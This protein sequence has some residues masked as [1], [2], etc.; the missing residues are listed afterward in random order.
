MGMRPP[1]YVPADHLVEVTGRTIQSRFLMR[2]DPVTRDLILGVLGRAQARYRVGIV[3]FVFLSNHYHMLLLP[4]SP[5]QLAEFM[6][7]V[8]SNIARELGRLHGWNARFWGRRYTS[9]PV[10]QEEAAQ[11]SR[12]RYLLA[13]GVKE[14]LVTRVREWPGPNSALAHLDG[15]AIEG[16]WFDRTA[17]SRAR[18]SGVVASL[19]EFASTERVALTP[20][21]C[22]STWSPLQRREAVHQLVADIESAGA[23]RGTHPLGRKAILRQHPHDMPTN[24]KRTPAPVFHAMTKP[25][26][27]ALSD[28]YRSFVL[29]F[30]EASERLRSGVRLV[31]FPPGSFP[32]ALPYVPIRAG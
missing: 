3:A 23:L 10:S 13:H 28:A 15:T 20:L 17:A 31:D 8:A 4:E 2:P 6:C 18:N 5:L 24:T 21:P 14:G 11:T 22:W 27:K 30:R 7:F 9:V 16:T 32:P 19:G 26:W 1:R 12:L 29:A 25:A